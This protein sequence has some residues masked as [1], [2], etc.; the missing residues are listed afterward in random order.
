MR[1][2]P[3]AASQAETLSKTM[4]EV[5]EIKQQTFTGDSVKE[6]IRSLET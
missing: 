1:Y 6:A 4:E 3:T 5:T 2:I